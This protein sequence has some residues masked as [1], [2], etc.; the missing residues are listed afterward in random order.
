[1]ANTYFNMTSGT[2][3]GTGTVG[4]VELFNTVISPGGNSVGTLNTGALDFA[5]GSSYAVTVAGSVA[6]KI[7]VNGNANVGGGTVDFT[8]SVSSCGTLSI[9]IL[10]TTGTLTGTFTLGTMLA[11]TSLSYDAHNVFLNTSGGSGRTFSGF[12]DTA[13][14]ASTAAA[15]DA[16]GC[17]NQP[18]S[19]EIN[20]LTDAQVPGAMDALSGEGHAAIAATFVQTSHYLS[21]AIDS[22]IE[23]AFAALDG[24]GTVTAFAPGP[25]LLESFA[26]ATVWASG[27]GGVAAQAANGNAAAINSA[28]SGLVLGADG[29]VTEDWRMGVIAGLGLTGISSGSTTGSSLDASVGGYAGAELGVVT[30]K[31]GAAYTRHFIGTSRSIVFPGVN[32]TVT[33]SYQAGTAQ[34]FFEI[35]KDFDVEGVTVSPFA[36]VLAV[37]HATD[38]FTETGGAGGALSTAASVSNALFVTLGVAAEDKF[39]LTDTMLVTAR[40]SL[41]WQ[42]AFADAPTVSNSFAG[43]GPFMISSVPLASDVAVLSGGLVFDISDA[44]NLAVS[45]DGMLGSGFASSAVTATLAGK[46]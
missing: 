1:M 10:T 22:R 14:Q 37:N 46:F 34:A 41:G 36:R 15:L 42:H 27:Y 2:L 23:Q 4:Q 28:A 25:M 29:K 45:Y 32:D 40:G 44:M 13:N 16:L 20:A 11:S 33:A 35:G 7:V 9:P 12:T 3:S 38:A 30:I 17:G 26:N 24:R 31:M 43:G 39:A 21:D 19:A 18:Y 8:G 5:G 6:D